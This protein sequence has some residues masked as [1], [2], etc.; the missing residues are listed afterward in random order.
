MENKGEKRVRLFPKETGLSER[1]GLLAIHSNAGKRG[2][3]ACGHDQN[4][5]QKK[6]K[7]RCW[8]DLHFAVRENTHI[9]EKKK[10]GGGGRIWAT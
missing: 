5:P 8:K 6:R 2:D 7:K 10:N 9:S 1:G 3:V 4:A